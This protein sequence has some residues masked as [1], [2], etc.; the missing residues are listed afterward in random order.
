MRSST[1][2][3]IVGIWINSQLGVKGDARVY[4]MRD[5]ASRRPW[6]PSLHLPCVG[7]AWVITEVVPDAML[8]SR[9]YKSTKTGACRRSRDGEAL[10]AT[11]YLT[12]AVV[13]LHSR[14]YHRQ[15]VIE[16]GKATLRLAKVIR[17]CLAPSH[18]P[19]SDRV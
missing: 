17:W 9:V 18:V 8:G 12:D 5:L 2:T 1:C 3:T 10:T 6:T 16:L 15:H 11:I 13:E 4:M 14:V 19:T 7:G